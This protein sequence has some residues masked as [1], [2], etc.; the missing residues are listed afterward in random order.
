M[1]ECAYVSVVVAVVVTLGLTGFVSAT[2]KEKEGRVAPER[3]KLGL[4]I[5]RKK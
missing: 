3:V 2:R 1:N 5:A 4:E